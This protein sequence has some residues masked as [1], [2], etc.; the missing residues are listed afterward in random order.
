MMC[1]PQHAHRGVFD[2]GERFGHDPRVGEITVCFE[3]DREAKRRGIFAERIQS[4]DNIAHRTPTCLGVVCVRQHVAE[5][6]NEFRPEFAGQI[7]VRS[8][9]LHFAR[10]LGGV[11]MIEP[12]GRT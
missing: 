8:P 11:G 10:K 2:R 12:H 5:D 3:N 9:R 4:V 6:A 1:I 7:E